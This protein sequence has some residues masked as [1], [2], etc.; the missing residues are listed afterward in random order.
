MQ[1]KSTRNRGSTGFPACLRSHVSPLI[2]SA[3]GLSSCKQHQMP[4]EVPN[5]APIPPAR[6]ELKVDTLVILLRNMAR[7]Q[8]LC[9]RS[10]IVV[11]RL[12]YNVAEA[13]IAYGRA[14]VTAA[15]LARVFE[16]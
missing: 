10:Q 15:Y 6:L 13:R 7:G 4:H 1:R 12:G 16:E 11:T 2:I 3:T 5:F 14:A 9:N 8:S